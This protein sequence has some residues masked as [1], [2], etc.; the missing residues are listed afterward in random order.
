VK[1]VIRFRD[2]KLT[3]LPFERSKILYEIEGIEENATLSAEPKKERPR[4]VILATGR[5]EGKKIEVEIGPDRIEERYGRS[6][7]EKDYGRVD[8]EKELRDKAMR[9]LARELEVKRTAEVTI[10]GIPLLERG[11]TLRWRTK[12]PGWHGENRRSRERQY[13]YVTAARHS[14]SPSR[15]TTGISVSQFD[16]YLADKRRREQEERDEKRKDRE[17]SG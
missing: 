4:T 12:E 8:S 6:V 10:P 15:Y 13:C 17:G 9:D 14:L 3:V 7:L 5:V 11:S 1:Y 16:P 2:G